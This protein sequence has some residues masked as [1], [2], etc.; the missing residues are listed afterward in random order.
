MPEKITISPR[1][2]DAL[3]RFS[4][5]HNTSAG[6]RVMRLQA[7]A[8]GAHELLVYGDIGE[9][10]WSDE[11]VTARG[12]VEQLRSI[13]AAATLTVRINSAGGSV[14]DGLAIHNALRRHADNGGRVEVQIDGVACSIASLIAAAG[15]TVTM[16]AN[17]L[18]MLHA[19]W[20]GLWFEGNAQHLREVA[21]EYIALLDTF[22]AAMAESY[23]RKTGRDAAEFVAMWAS[24]KDYW[25]TAA[26]AAAAG[27]CDAVTDTATPA[28]DAAAAS[29]QLQHLIARAPQ[30]LQASVRAALVFSPP[31]AD[32]AQQQESDM[33]AT[34][35]PAGGENQAP[36]TPTPAASATDATAAVQSTVQA[37]RARN[38]EIRSMAAPYA[39]NA[40]VQAYINSVIDEADASVSAGDAGRQILAILGKSRQPLNGGGHV[41]AGQDER[42]NRS[43]AMSAAI[44]ARLGRGDAKAM[45]SNEFAN[46]TLSEMA[47]ACAQFAGVDTRGM[48]AE[49]YIRAAITHTSSDFPRLLGDTFQRSL[50]RGYQEVPEVFDQFTRAIPVS[51]FRKQSLA[52]LGQFIG[53]EEVRE[54]AEY[55]YGTFSETGQEMRLKKRGAI[56]SITAEAIQNDDLGVFDSVP[57]KMG[58][59]TK[60][61]LADD[62][63]ALLTSNPVQGDGVALFHANHRNLLTG[64]ELSSKSIGDAIAAMAL[65]K[66]SAGHPVRILARYL[67]VPVGLG[68][69]ARQILDSQFEVGGAAGK[70]ATVPNVVRGRFVVVEDPRLDAADAKSWYMVADP[71]AVDGIVIAYLNGVQAPTITQREG[72]N[73]DGIEIKVRLAAAAGV[74]DWRA[75][76]KN[77]G[78]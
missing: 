66:D 18:M 52:G 76:V 75:L 70:N 26:E 38:A 59:A 49:Q 53:V 50:L 67:V 5:A 25:Y 13:P 33:T 73:V 69:V 44:D 22:G 8:S 71:A 62:V 55:P 28:A 31:A 27:L 63:F 2:R 43:R 77:P 30:P 36:A 11:S 34:T 23:A 24:G 9:S 42:S 6:E 65:Q 51:D 20:G 21:D 56:F 19:P 78:Q 4:P 7:S 40:E 48:S 57:Y 46:M 17:T 47:R 35:Q 58:Q 16:P 74:A 15:D 72:F 14:S 37:L 54:G 12:V 60:R 39:D 64:A 1:L 29:G 32:A 10:W 41:V 61:S 45:D 3:A 68:A